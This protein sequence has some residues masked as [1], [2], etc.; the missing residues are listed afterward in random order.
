MI[1][2]FEC[3][4]V[5]DART[6]EVYARSLFK[7]LRDIKRFSISY[8]ALGNWFDYENDSIWNIDH[9]SRS[10]E[11]KLSNSKIFFK[12]DY[13]GDWHEVTPDVDKCIKS[14]A[15]LGFK[16]YDFDKKPPQLFL[17]VEY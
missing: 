16:V 1:L 7:D 17:K 12:N 15:E 8:K 14:L 6:K 3:R 2:L 9:L 10:P 13:S 11:I 4:T 5:S